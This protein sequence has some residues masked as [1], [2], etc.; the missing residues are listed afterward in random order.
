MD[1][2]PTRQFSV[3]SSILLV[4]FLLLHPLVASAQKDSAFPQA[5][6]HEADRIAKLAVGN[7]LRY[8][9]LMPN[10]TVISSDVKTANAYIKSGVRYIAYNPEFIYRLRNRSKTDWAAVSV[11]AHEIG[12][13]LAGHT[14]RQRGTNPGD[15]LAADQFSGFIL[16]QMGATLEETQAALTAIGGE[17]D[18]LRHPPSTARLES[19]SNGWREA[20]TLDHV[21]AYG[22]QSDS[23]PT[24]TLKVVYQCQFR[25]DENLYFINHLD[26]IIWYDNSGKAIVIG[27]KAPSESRSYAW[28]YRYQQFSFGVDANG[29]IWEETTFGS[30]HPVGKV[31]LIGGN[32]VDK[33]Q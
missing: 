27:Q 21:P 5:Y 30:V 12:H 28:Y 19:I 11:L 15:E 20:Q 23:L 18:T 24:D 1:L 26:E 31:T 10:F 16:Y 22:P 6:M 29:T 3:F 9:G 13:H 33:N 7:I 32:V 4:L 17:I 2:F 14:I 25:N 8:T